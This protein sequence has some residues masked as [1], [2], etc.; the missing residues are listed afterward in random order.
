[1]IRRSGSKT[2]N[3]PCRQASS[4]D[5]LSISGPPYLLA[6]GHR[7]LNEIKRTLDLVAITSP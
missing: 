1:M 3:R 7:A 5:F 6:L 2:F 4:L